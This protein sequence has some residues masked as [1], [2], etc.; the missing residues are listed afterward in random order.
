MSR[1]SSTT[2]TSPC[3]PGRRQG[4]PVVLRPEGAGATGDLAWQSWG[5]FGRTDRPALPA[6]RRLRRDLAGDRRRAASR[7]ATIR[8]GSTSLPNGVPVPEEPWQRRPDWRQRPARVFVGPARARERACDTLIAAWPGVRRA[9]PDGPADPDRRG[10]RAARAG[11][12]GPRARPGPRARRARSSCPARGRR[13]RGPARAPTCSSCPRGGGH[14][15]RPAG[16]DGP[17]HPAGRLVDPRQPPPGQRLQARPPRPARA[18]PRPWPG[19]SST[20][21]P[22]ST[23]PS[24]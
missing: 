13:R 8:P 24:T 17:G 18:T 15:H 16:G 22:T 11:G 20:S 7:P 19:R 6:G 14:E 10:A 3:R 5:S 4:F 1:C 12:A 9:H 23:A 21:G 2:P